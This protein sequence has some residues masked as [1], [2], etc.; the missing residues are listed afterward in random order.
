MIFAP[1]V[2]SESIE[3]ED[4]L[5]MKN[6]AEDVVEEDDDGSDEDTGEQGNEVS[7]DSFKEGDDTV[8]TSETI[9]TTRSDQIIKP[10]KRL[11]DTMTVQC[12]GLAAELRYLSNMAELELEEM[13]MHE[14]SAQDLELSAVGAGVGGGFKSTDKLRVVNYKEVINSKDAEAWKT[15][16]KCKKDRFD[17]FGALTP[18]KRNAVLKG[19][20]FM[21]TT[22]AMKKKASGSLEEN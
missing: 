15:E 13:H 5:A 6:K 21:T 12:K 1:A 2:K 9:L 11:M 20:K 19:S 8:V 7:N 16:I 4:L 18:V 10:I 3:L 17:K 14:L 22:W